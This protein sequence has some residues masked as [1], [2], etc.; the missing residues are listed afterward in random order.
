MEYIGIGQRIQDYR[1]DMKY[2]MEVFAEKVESNKSNVS[3]WES[4]VNIPNEATLHK[5]A[6]AVNVTYE[7]LVY[8]GL[9]DMLYFIFI[10]LKEISKELNH[11]DTILHLINGPG[12]SDLAEELWEK[13]V[14]PNHKKQFLN[15]CEK[16]IQISIKDAK[17]RYTHQINIIKNN[18][19]ISNRT[20]KTLEKNNSDDFEKELVERYKNLDNFIKIMDTDNTEEIAI[21]ILDLESF[22][23]N[24]ESISGESDFIVTQKQIAYAIRLQDL[25]NDGV[26]DLDYPGGIVPDLIDQLSVTVRVNEN[27]LADYKYILAIYEHTNSPIYCGAMYDL[28]NLPIS[29]SYNYICIK[30]DQIFVSKIDND[31]VIFDNTSIKINE[32]DYIL[33]LLEIIF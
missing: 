12:I 4:D 15:I 25:I 19:E 31:F 30:N 16:H 1:I 13:K 28:I 32:L 26:K 2:T 22:F 8:G 6:D 29:K 5:I 14:Y 21:N 23:V 10:N 24:F 7:Q 20:F 3:R 17:E 18:Y 33:P 11:D 27:T 9:P